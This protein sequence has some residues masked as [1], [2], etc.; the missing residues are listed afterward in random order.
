[1]SCCLKKAPRKRGVKKKR[2]A[3]T[4][5]TMKKC[6]SQCARRPRSHKDGRTGIG[7]A[8]GTVFIF[9]SAIMSSILTPSS[10]PPP[11]PPFPPTATTRAHACTH[12]H[13]V[14]FVGAIAARQ[15]AWNWSLQR[16][17]DYQR[18]TATRKT[19]GHAGE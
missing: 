1:M 10:A 4:N 14:V 3:A 9:H 11:Y 16:V 7:N 5:M 15:A 19:R 12:T 8:Y 18:D 17:L 6:T 13:T 2:A